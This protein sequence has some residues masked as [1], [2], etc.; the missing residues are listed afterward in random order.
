MLMTLRSIVS[1]IFLRHRKLKLKAVKVLE[2][3]YKPIISQYS[4]KTIIASD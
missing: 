3:L 2:F 1:R 4:I